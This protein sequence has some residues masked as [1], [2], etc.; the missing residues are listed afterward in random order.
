MIIPFTLPLPPSVNNLYLN[1]RGRGRVKSPAYRAWLDEAAAICSDAAWRHN[2]PPPDSRWSLE[3]VCVMPN[4]RR[5]DLDNAAK[6][7]IDFL[8][9]R[10]GLDDNRLVALTLRKEVVRGEAYIAGEVRVVSE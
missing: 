3:A 2:P 7:A 6:A 5:R 8:A 10:L 1:L 9:A 4:W